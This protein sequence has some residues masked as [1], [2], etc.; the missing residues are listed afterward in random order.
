MITTQQQLQCP[1]CGALLTLQQQQQGV[2]DAVCQ[3]SNTPMV[4]NVPFVAGITPDGGLILKLTMRD[5]LDL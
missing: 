3:W 2:Q 4:D 5:G 1:S